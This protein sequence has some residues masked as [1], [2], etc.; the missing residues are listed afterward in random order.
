MIENR[1]RFYQWLRI[2][3]ISHR[4]V[5]VSLANT[6]VPV[7]CV[8][9]AFKHAA[10]SQSSLRSRERS[11]LAEALSL[12]SRQFTASS[13][14]SILFL[15]SLFPTLVSLFLAFLVPPSI[16]SFSTYIIRT[17]RRQSVQRHR[18]RHL[19]RLTPSSSSSSF[20]LLSLSPPDLPTSTLSLISFSFSSL[21]NHAVL[22]FPPRISAC[23][24]V[25]F[26]RPSR[27]SP[28]RLKSFFTRLVCEEENAAKNRAPFV[29]SATVAVTVCS[30]PRC[31]NDKSPSS[32]TFVIRC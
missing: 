1:R 5:D 3:A 19:V 30:C 31:D 8:L 13:L 9:S 6:Y 23:F 27:A 11:V 4:Y 26:K 7:T 28:L 20:P 25:L 29:N 16:L 12:C 18:C 15:F 21:V 2:T 22:S 10:C 17:T 14:P 24:G 32:P